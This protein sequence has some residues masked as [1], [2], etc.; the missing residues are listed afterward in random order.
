MAVKRR[1]NRNVE[2]G[3]LILRDSWDMK[4]D[5]I[6]QSLLKMYLECPRKFLIKINEYESDLKQKQTA[7]GSLGHDILEQCYAKKNPPTDNDLNNYIERYYEKN[8]DKIIFDA[9]TFEEL[10]AKALATLS[11]YFEYYRD[12]FSKFNWLYLEKTFNVD[13][14]LQFKMRGKVDGKVATEKHNVYL[15]ENKFFSQINEENLLLQL[16][17]DLQP[18]YY[19]LADK[20]QHGTQV[21]GMLYNIIRNTSKKPLKLESL[22]K[23][24]NRLRSEILKN[25]EYYFFRKPFHITPKR[26]SDFYAELY[27]IVEQ[28]Q[29]DIEKDR[30]N[31]MNYASCMKVYFPCEYI[32]ACSKNTM[33]GFK[34]VSG[35]L[36]QE[37]ED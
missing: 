18:L 14:N 24:V 21:S 30:L 12:D 29:E 15:W 25:P 33:Q 28:M 6:T 11:A 37:L 13:F 27:R 35:S 32:A 2:P 8:K 10:S 22:P 19:I 26:I 34:R 31:R 5:G 7:F 17:L 9:Q 23:Y 4:K 3:S 20:L 1:R 36:Y 16:P